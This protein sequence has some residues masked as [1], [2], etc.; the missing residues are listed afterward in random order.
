MSIK[1]SDKLSP[2]EFQQTVGTE[3]ERYEAYVLLE[4]RDG[5]AMLS[6]GFSYGA[7]FTPEQLISFGEK[8]IQIGKHLQLRG[9]NPPGGEPRDLEEY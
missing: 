1:N 6:T 4:E 9:G 7:V 5:N 8:V 2:Y 3:S